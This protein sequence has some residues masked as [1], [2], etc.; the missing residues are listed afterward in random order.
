VLVCEGDNSG[1][2]KETVKPAGSAK[3]RPPEG[4]CVQRR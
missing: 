2:G 3:G 4:G 1:E